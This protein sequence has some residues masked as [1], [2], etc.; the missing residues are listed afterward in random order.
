[1]QTITELQKTLK[2]AMAGKAKAD[3]TKYNTGII[4]DLHSPE[5]NVFYMLGI[6]Q[7]LF[8]KFGISE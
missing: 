3:G 5:G 7:D 6:C 2:M 8:R 1:M 4:I